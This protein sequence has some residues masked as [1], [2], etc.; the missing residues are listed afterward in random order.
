MCLWTC[1]QGQPH[2][3]MSLVVGDNQQVSKIPSSSHLSVN[4][5]DSNFLEPADIGQRASV[6]PDK[7]GQRDAG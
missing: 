2:K 3:D 1:N 7:H 6:Q 4:T 5:D